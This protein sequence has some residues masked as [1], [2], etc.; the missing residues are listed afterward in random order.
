MTKLVRLDEWKLAPAEQLEFMRRVAEG[1][2]PKVICEALGL[3][4]SATMG[5][6]KATPLLAAQYRSA[7][8]TWV[9]ALAH[10][11]V[12]IADDTEG[13]EDAAAV[14][15]AKLRC[16][17]RFRLAAKL[18]REM[19]GE[20][21]KAAVQVNVNLGDIAREIRDLEQRLGIG[22]AAGMPSGA[23]IDVQPAEIVTTEPPI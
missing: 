7:L 21:V 15:A 10:E 14:A 12:Q 6:I 13:A 18:Y 4:R 17:T 8:E 1:D 3:P 2:T 23:V 19:F 5:H 16:D 11:T 22:Q 20:D 9:E